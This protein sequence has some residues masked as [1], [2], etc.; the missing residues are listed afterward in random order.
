MLN[1]RIAENGIPVR[2]FQLEKHRAE[3]DVATADGHAL[4][5]YPITVIK[6]FLPRFVS[7]REYRLMAFLASSQKRSGSD[8]HH[9]AR[10][11]ALCAILQGKPFIKKGLQGG[12]SDALHSAANLAHKNTDKIKA[13]LTPAPKGG[14]EG[15]SKL[16]P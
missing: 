10:T 16:R 9:E 13:G 6:K 11:E 5:S 4:R 14:E 1:G 3:P 8:L 15:R 7:K 2:T 12:D